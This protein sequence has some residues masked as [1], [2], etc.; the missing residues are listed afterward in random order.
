MMDASTLDK[1]Q[2]EG[3]NAL[4]Y[5]PSSA[6]LQLSRSSYYQVF[7]GSGFQINDGF[8]PLHRALFLPTLHQK[9]NPAQQPYHA[10]YIGALWQHHL[11]IAIPMGIPMANAAKTPFPRR[12][13]LEALAR[14]TLSRP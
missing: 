5:S 13:F 6:D 1:V 14:L 12:D 8:V 4:C 10:R 2:P 9:L 3:S 7:K 11:G